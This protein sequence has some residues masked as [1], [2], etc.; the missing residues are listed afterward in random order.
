[1]E[2]LALIIILVLIIL[3]VRSK[4]KREKQR[5]EQYYQ[6]EY[7][8]QTQNSYEQIISDEGLLGEFSIYKALN[9]LE[10]PRKFL[11]NLYLPKWNGGTTELDVVLL[12]ESGIYVFES[13]S[14]GGWIFGSE[15][16]KYWTQ[17][18][19]AGRRRSQKHR[20]YNPILQND[21]H[22]DV[23]FKFLRSTH[24]SSGPPPY[25]S[26]IVFSNRCVLKDV[27]KKSGNHHILYLGEL[28]FAVRENVVETGVHLTA[29]EI[30]ILY[31]KLEPYSHVDETVKQAHI[32]NIRSKY[33]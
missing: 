23:L 21:G 7:A 25:Y 8:A 30:E 22:L 16:Q 11:F 20:F 3:S 2:P 24:L 27:P 5:R 31:E 18:L 6:T 4:N 17:T 33:R 13:K 10:G 32:E 19:P 12:H 28:L 15:K 9:S 29:A 1:M 14:Y 26:Y